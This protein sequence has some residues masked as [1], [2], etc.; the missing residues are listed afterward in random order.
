[1]KLE[2]IFPDKEY[3]ANLK[4]VAKEFKENPTPYDISHMTTLVDFFKANH[5][6]DY[7]ELADTKRSIDQPEGFVPSTWLWVVQDGKIVAVADIRHT[8]N[9]YLRNVCGGH[10][11]YGIVPSYRGKGL[12]NPIGKLLL[13]YARDHFGINEALITCHIENTP[14]YKVILRLMKE[15]GG[16]P[17]TDTFVD[18]HIEKRCWVLTEKED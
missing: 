6:E 4:S 16:H 12:M 18:D 11:A 1:M 5:L 7:F 3:M 2:L 15:M 13:K 10:I 14:S 8:L 9:D 17:D